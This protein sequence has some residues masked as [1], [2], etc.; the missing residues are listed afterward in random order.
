VGSPFVLIPQIVADLQ[1]ERGSAHV[2]GDAA[3]AAAAAADHA[4]ESEKLLASRRAQVTKAKRRTKHRVKSQKL[5]TILHSV[6]KA[7]GWAGGMTKLEVDPEELRKGERPQDWPLLSVVSDEGP[8]CMCLRNW[9]GN[10]T[11]NVNIDWDWDP[12]HSG[13]HSA[14]H[15]MNRAGLRT[16]DMLMTF[17]YNVGNGEWK[18]GARREQILQSTNDTLATS[19]GA[20]NDVAF[21]LAAPYLRQARESLDAAPTV[22]QDELIYAALKEHNC[23][24]E[25]ETRLSFVSFKDSN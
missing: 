23:W 17:A 25:S 18:D 7:F 12:C 20:A 2:A 16:H 11:T 15:G 9:I 4:Q 10:V 6:L 5:G 14:Q 22:E 19:G 21:R 24:H 3:G 13:H 8:D 1:T